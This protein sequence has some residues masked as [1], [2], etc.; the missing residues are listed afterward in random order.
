[1]SLYHETSP[2]IFPPWSGEPIN[3][4]RYPLSI[5]QQWSAP[6]LATIDLYLPAD[7]DPVPDGKVVVATD[8]RRVDGVVRHVHTLED[9][10]PPAPEQI[11]E[12]FRVAIQAHVDATA[13]SRL[14]DGGNSLATYVSSTNPQWAAEAVAFV[15][16]RDGVWAYSY[17]ELD[18]V[19]IGQRGQPTIEAFLAELPPIVWPA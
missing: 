6:E 8:V 4:V 14:Y 7:A 12:D 3:G 10:A 16:W 11:I 17:A 2:G 5:E 18:K 15:A 19:L 9:A 13:I 1:M